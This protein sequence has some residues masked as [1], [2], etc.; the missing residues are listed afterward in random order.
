MDFKRHAPARTR[1]VFRRQDPDAE[2]LNGYYRKKS[3]CRII[4]ICQ[5]MKLAFSK[6][7]GLVCQNN[8]SLNPVD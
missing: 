1:V 7:K 8:N 3:I 2:R 4:A 5:N 6:L